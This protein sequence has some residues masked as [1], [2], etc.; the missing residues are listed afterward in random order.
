M[1]H[2]DLAIKGRHKLQYKCVQFFNIVSVQLYWNYPMSLI[3]IFSYLTLKL[4]L[5]TQRFT[6][7]HLH[8]F[9]LLLGLK[10][11]PLR[12]YS[13]L[14]WTVH[15]VS[16][17]LQRFVLWQQFATVG[18]FRNP[19]KVTASIRETLR[20]QLSFAVQ[21]DRRQL[22]IQP[23]PGTRSSWGKRVESGNFAPLSKPGASAWTA[24]TAGKNRLPVHF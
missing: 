22:K 11:S 20:H 4:L 14:T 19:H 17:Q 7:E 13:H 9:W 10:H 12:L 2:I 3:F 16:V 1:E 21:K 6:P 5:N 18:T 15:K 23:A 8:A 24:K